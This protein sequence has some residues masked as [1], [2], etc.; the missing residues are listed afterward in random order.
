VAELR[1]NRRSENHLYFRH[2]GNETLVRPPF[3]HLT[4]LLGQERFIEFSHR[5]SFRLGPINST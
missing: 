1:M 4:R 5:E 3:N 2:E